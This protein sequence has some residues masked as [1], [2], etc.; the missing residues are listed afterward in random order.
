VGA[1]SWS[2]DSKRIAFSATRDPDL[3]SG[4]TAQLYLVNL[5]D[6]YVKKL[7]D[8]KGPNNGP[9]WA[10]DGRE[11]AY[12]TSNGAEFFYYSNT[13]VAAIAVEG[14]SP[15]ILTDR[16]DEDPRIVKWGTPRHLLRRR[17]KDRHASLPP[18]PAIEEHPADQRAGALQHRLR[19]TEP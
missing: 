6:K 16:F 10:P 11:I 5:A 14:G 4:G 17:P 13:K 3:S 8:G 12:S 15:R 1:F 18:Q 2:P 19:F 9:V 7:T